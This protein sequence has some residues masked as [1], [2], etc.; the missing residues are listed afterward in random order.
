[1]G[2]AGRERQTANFP[3]WLEYSVNSFQATVFHLTHGLMDEQHLV[4]SSHLKWDSVT[5]S[6]QLS[7]LHGIKMTQ[8]SPTQSAWS[9]LQTW[10]SLRC[11]FSPSAGLFCF[12]D[13]SHRP[14]S[15]LRQLFQCPKRNVP[16]LC[17]N[18]KWA[19]ISLLFFLVRCFIITNSNKGFF[20]LLLKI[21]SSFCLPSVSSNV[22]GLYPRS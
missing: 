10:D 19:F 21:F 1:M 13:F 5:L 8:R 17:A 20:F 7:W 9:A 2:G 6:Y 18:S 16:V 15:R 4:F 11:G 12:C 22:R 3:R 14:R